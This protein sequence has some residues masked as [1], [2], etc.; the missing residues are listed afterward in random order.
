MKK[1]AIRVGRS[2]A[3]KAGNKRWQ[4]V[5]VTVPKVLREEKG[6]EA[7]DILEWFV[8]AEGKVFVEFRKVRRGGENVRA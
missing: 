8:D 1:R 4:S 3:F 6:F 5:V 7:G 2:K